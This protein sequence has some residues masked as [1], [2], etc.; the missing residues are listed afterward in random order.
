V[1]NVTH[2]LYVSLENVDVRRDILGLGS[3]AL[4]V[5]RNTLA[6]VHKSALVSIYQ[7]DVTS[8][9]E[10]GRDVKWKRLFRW[11]QSDKT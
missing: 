5:T 9:L 4:K 11:P 8:F 7:T 10:D 1:R 3:T 2:R 6:S